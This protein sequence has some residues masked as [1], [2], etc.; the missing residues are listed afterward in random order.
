M[1]YFTIRPQQELWWCGFL[2]VSRV[3][4][5]DKVLRAPD[6]GHCRKPPCR[7][8]RVEDFQKSEHLMALEGFPQNSLAVGIH[9]MDHEN[10]LCP[11]DLNRCNLHGRLLSV[12]S[13]R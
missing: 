8:G 9:P 12:V 10:R 4:F 3:E 7:Q 6:G 1:A 2:G 5:F 13:F 11:I